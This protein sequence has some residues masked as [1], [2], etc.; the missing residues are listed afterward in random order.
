MKAQEIKVGSIF[1]NDKNEVREVES[2]SKGKLL[3]QARNYDTGII[4]KFRYY[5]ASGLYLKMG[6]NV[7][8]GVLKF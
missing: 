7:G 8:L 6:T 2:I 4:E 1:R 3:V 5:N